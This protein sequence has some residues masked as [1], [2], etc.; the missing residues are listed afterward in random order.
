[1]TVGM[2]RARCRAEVLSPSTRTPSTFRRPRSR[3]AAISRSASPRSSPTGQRR[4]CTSGSRPRAR[5]RAAVRAARRPAVLERPHPLRPHPQQD[6]EGHRRQ[7]AHDGR[8]SARRTCPGW[9]THG[10]PIELAVERELGPKRKAMSAAE[11]RQACRDYALKFVDD[12]AHRVQAARRA[13]RLGRP[14]PDARHDVRGRDRARARGVR[15]RRLAL[16]RQEAGAL[17]PARPD[18]ARRGRDRVRG[19]SVAVGLRAVPARRRAAS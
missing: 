6:P 4:S 8:A 3:C 18:G 2:V 1:M 16:P 5:G 13:R 14:V 15:A 7:V 9:D 19:H 17:V 12:P 11:I 10:L